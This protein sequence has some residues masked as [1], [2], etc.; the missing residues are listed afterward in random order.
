VFILFIYKRPN[1][2]A[3]I[4]SILPK[5]PYLSVDQGRFGM[6]QERMGEGLGCCKTGGGL[7]EETKDEIG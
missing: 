5:G 1:I 7:G 4:S 6:L 3:V 2:I